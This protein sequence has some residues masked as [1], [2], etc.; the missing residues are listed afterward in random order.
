MKFTREDFQTLIIL[1]QDMKKLRED[2]DALR[3]HHSQSTFIY[4]FKNNWRLLSFIAVAT[5]ATVEF[6][7]HFIPK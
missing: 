1:E 6:F 2:F 5:G 7:Y 4:F 3:E